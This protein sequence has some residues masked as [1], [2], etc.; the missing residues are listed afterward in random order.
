MRMGHCKLSCFR[1]PVA[2]YALAGKPLADE[3]VSGRV[4]TG[5]LPAM[6]ARSSA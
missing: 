6:A 5:R 4:D 2:A 1:F 3:T